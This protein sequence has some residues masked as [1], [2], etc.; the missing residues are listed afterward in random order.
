VHDASQ[1]S[2]MRPCSGQPPRRNQDLSRV[3]SLTTTAWARAALDDH[4]G[5]A[6]EGFP[7]VSTAPARHRRAARPASAGNV[8]YQAYSAGHG[9]PARPVRRHRPSRQ[10]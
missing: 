6:A 5:G 9:Q 3:R 8:A 1:S 4:G 7:A 10:G 2:Q